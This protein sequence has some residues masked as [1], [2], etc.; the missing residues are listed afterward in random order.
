[1]MNR[2]F[3]APTEEEIR[4]RMDMYKK[5]DKLGID[6]MGFDNCDNAEK[7]H[8]D[9]SI[10]TRD[11]PFATKLPESVVTRGE[12]LE[13]FEEMRMQTADVPEM[14]LDEIN[15]EIRSVRAN[16]KKEKVEILKK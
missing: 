10:I 15:E 13:A 3:T 16:R 9:R 2:T 8:T 11:I 12:G 6:L 1:M 7:M 14:S 4:A 5:A